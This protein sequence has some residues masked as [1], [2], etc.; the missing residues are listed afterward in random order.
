[1]SHSQFIHPSP[2]DLPRDVERSWLRATKTGEPRLIALTF[3]DGPIA[4]ATEDILNALKVHGWSATFCVLGQ[5][6]EHHAGLLCR[7]VAEGHEV[8]AH[9]WSHANL[10]DI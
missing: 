1:M 9:G 4:G 10:M 2:I 5:Q 6:V 3:D 8:A 7:M